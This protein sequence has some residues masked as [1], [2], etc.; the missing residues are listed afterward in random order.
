M[1]ARHDVQFDKT[2]LWSKLA[3]PLPVGVISWRQDGRPSQRDGKFFSRFVAYIE[4]N[5]VRERLDSVVP[6]EWDLTLELLPP[7]PA[8]D[9]T[10]DGMLCSFKARLQIVGVIREDVGTGK[11]YKQAAT[12]AFK[13][14]STFAFRKKIEL[15]ARERD[16]SSEPDANIEELPADYLPPFVLEPLRPD[17][18]YFVERTAWQTEILTLYETWATERVQGSIALVGEAGGGKTTLML[19]LAEALR[20][21]AA[22]PICWRDVV[23][24]HTTRRTALAFVAELFDLGIVPQTK[25]ELLQHLERAEPRVVM[26]DDCHHFFV[27]QIGGFEG[28]E[29]LLDVVNLTDTRH[30]W[31]LSFNIYAW[32]Y[33]NRVSPREHYFGRVLDLGRWTDEEIQTLV[34][35]R[36]MQTQYIAS[37]S[38]LVISHD[39]EGTN[40]FEVVKTARG[41]FRYLHEYSGGNPTLAIVFWLRSLRLEGANTLQVSL[42]R[43]PTTSHL[44]GISDN[45]WFL[46]AALAQHGELTAPE[47]A[48]IV[49]ADEGFCYLALNFFRDRGIVVIDAQTQRAKLTPLYF[50]FVLRWLSNSNFLYR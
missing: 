6:G 37:F 35:R 20:A 42:F 38:D 2:D 49:N 30:F 3:A 32:S 7:L 5:T 9:E 18:P 12:D 15:Q 17:S 48:A 36:T 14:A 25:L 44:D 41:Y 39:A 43:R 31:V 34:E 4:A 11:D 23:Q 1:I 13:R 24:K 46:L 28:L 19:Q 22:E 10:G 29:T 45:H 47:A 40:Y 33:V 27:R 50:R 21:R 8:S 16:A 26:L